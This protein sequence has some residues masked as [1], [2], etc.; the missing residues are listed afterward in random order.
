MLASGARKV[1]LASPYGT[2]EAAMPFCSSQSLVF[3]CRVRLCRNFRFYKMLKGYPR[4]S[5]FRW[6]RHYGKNEVQWIWCY[7]LLRG[8]F[9]K[10]RIR[11]VKN[12]RGS[13]SL[14]TPRKIG[15]SPVLFFTG[16]VPESLPKQG[17]VART[18]SGHTGRVRSHGQ[19]PVKRVGSGRTGV[20]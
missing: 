11:R 3:I 10:S 7:H 20:G 18:G 13:S 5:N 19:G 15:Q 8:G 16:R 1:L 6:T 9:R 14:D 12:P 4:D 2:C 17:S